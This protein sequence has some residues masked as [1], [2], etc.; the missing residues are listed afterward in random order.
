MVEKF[1]SAANE[2]GLRI[3]MRKNIHTVYNTRGLRHLTVALVLI[4]HTELA[5]FTTWM[6]LMAREKDSRHTLKSHMIEYSVKILFH[7]IQTNTE[8]LTKKN[9]LCLWFLDKL[10]PWNS[11]AVA[12]TLCVISEIPAGYLFLLYMFHT[13]AVSSQQ[14]S[15]LEVQI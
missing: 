4:S 7:Y 15:M 6:T 8:T 1:W 13:Q 11:L 10:S 5:S 2:S 14:N 12:D 3:N 9:E